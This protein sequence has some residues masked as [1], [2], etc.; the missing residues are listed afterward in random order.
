MHTLNV[1]QAAA[2]TGISK[3]TLDKRRVYG[4]GP[5]YFKIGARVIYNQ[6]DLDTWL[7]ARKVANTSKPFVTAA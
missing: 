5:T 6:A 2:Y 3:S 7:C 1:T 4:N